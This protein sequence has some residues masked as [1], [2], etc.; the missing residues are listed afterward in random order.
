MSSNSIKQEVEDEVDQLRCSIVDLKD[1]ILKEEEE[2]DFLS[3]S[4]K[5]VGKEVEVTKAS[6]EKR[7]RAVEELKRLIIEEAKDFLTQ[8][9]EKN[10]SVCE[11]EEEQ[12]PNSCAT[13]L[14]I[15]FV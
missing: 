7:R 1:E 14:T 13:R 3:Q 8:I 15:I 5:S 12:P 10:N 11:E 9:V 4:R 6:K 2:H